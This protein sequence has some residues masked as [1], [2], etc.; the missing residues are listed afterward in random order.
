[1]ARINCGNKILDYSNYFSFN[2][3]GY[4]KVAIINENI[5]INKR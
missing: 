4:I 2:W 1:L 3:F 5:K